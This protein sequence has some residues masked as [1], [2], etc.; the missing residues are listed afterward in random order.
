MQIEDRLWT[1]NFILMCFANLL[2]SVAFYFLIPCLPVFLEKAMH[3]G[4]SQIGIVFAVYTLAALLIRPF[5]GYFVDS[6]GRSLIFL[7]SFFV[8][9]LIFGAFSFAVTLSQVIILRFIHGLA[10]GISTTSSST[11]IVDIIPEKRR[12]EGLGY[13]GI[14]MTIGLALGP[15]LGTIIAGNNHFDSMFFV[16]S[17]LSLS[18]F[19]MASMVKFPKFNHKSSSP[20]FEWS[21]LIELSSVPVSLIILMVCVSYG[22]VIIFVSLYAKEIKIENSGLFFLIYAVGLALSRLTAGKIFDKYGPKNICFLGFL[23]LISGLFILSFIKN[24]PGFYVSAL[25]IGVGF[26]IIFPVFQAM[27][28][29]IVNVRQRGVAN[30]TFFTAVDIG[31][32]FGAVL[33]GYLAEQ[34]S[35]TFTFIV[36]T[37]IVFIAVF[38]FYIFILPIYN[39]KVK[40]IEN[41]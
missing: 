20:K 12:G 16:A 24:A 21:K 5:A 19:I 17:L 1:R 29:N 38:A 39:K 7:I 11:V 30:S 25:F 34:F 28:N 32:G 31:I 14:A 6:Y 9:S 2:M 37:L 10:W 33:S 15:Y 27:I 36:C 13:F 4:K 41:Q 35:L 23:F 22:G 3:A 40:S 26:G 18:G 8:F